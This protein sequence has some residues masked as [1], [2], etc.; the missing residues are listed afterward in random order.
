MKK[1]LALYTNKGQ[2]KKNITGT[3][4]LHFFFSPSF[5]VNIAKI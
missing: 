3:F 5:F 1:M 2:K 4:L